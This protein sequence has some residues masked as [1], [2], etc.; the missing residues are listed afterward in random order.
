MANSQ[1]DR[2]GIKSLIPDLS[3]QRYDL[4]DISLFLTG[5][6]LLGIGTGIGGI[7]A[8]VMFRDLISPTVG[9]KTL[10]ET[11]TNDRFSSA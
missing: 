6:I 5:A 8:K 2:S 7:I 11:G 3:N 4:W 1:D 9:I 10:P